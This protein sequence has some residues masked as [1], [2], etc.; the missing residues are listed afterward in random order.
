MLLM[1]LTAT[2]NYYFSQR[3]Q[4]GDYYMETFRTHDN[5]K[6][7]FFMTSTIRDYTINGTT[8]MEIDHGYGNIKT[9]RT[10]FPSSALKSNSEPAYSSAHREL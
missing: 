7:N 5:E 10:I 8:I 6:E 1:K 3:W 9:A 2:T 4:I